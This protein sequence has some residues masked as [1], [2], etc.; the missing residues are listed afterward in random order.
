MC[1]RIC[2]ITQDDSKLLRAK[3]TEIRKKLLFK[4]G[5]ITEEFLNEVEEL[6]RAY[7]YSLAIGHKMNATLQGKHANIRVDLLYEEAKDMSHT[8]WNEWISH[9]I[10]FPS[11]DMK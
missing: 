3:F 1:N 11:Q 2:F 4:E 7:F 8:K 9:H 10:Q 6:K 5:R